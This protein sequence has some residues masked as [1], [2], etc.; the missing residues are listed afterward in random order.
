MSLLQILPDPVRENAMVCVIFVLGF[1]LI[2]FYLFPVFHGLLISPTRNIPGPIW[3][4]V[5]RW[6]EYQAV[7]KDDSHIRYI[8]LH[9]KY[10]A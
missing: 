9:E 2:L 8:R 4:R 6:W 10:G 1:P 7:L 5:T 3:A